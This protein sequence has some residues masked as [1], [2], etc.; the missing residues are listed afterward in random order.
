M[1][2]ILSS[3]QHPFKFK[4]LCT[5]ISF[6]LLSSTGGVAVAQQDGP[7]V[8]EVIVTGSFIRR[9]E[10]FIAASPI[11]QLSAEDI[12]DQG[13]LNMSQIV[14]NMTFN[15]GTG[16]TTGIQA[17][18]GSANSGGFNLRGLGR[19]AT[20]QLVDG[21]RITNSNIQTLIPNIAIQRMDIVTDGAAALYGTDA[22]AGVINFLPYKS[23]DGLKLEHFNEEDSEGDFRDQTTS[24]LWGTQL[25]DD[26]DFVIAGA[27]RHNG[28]LKWTDRPKLALAG[29][30]D[31]SGSNPTSW[32]VPDRDDDGALLGTTTRTPEPICGTDPVTDPMVQ[33]NNKYGTLALGRCWMPF[34]DTRDYLNQKT[35]ANLYSNLNWDVN[36]DLT[37]GAQLLWSRAMI[38]ARNNQGNPGTRNEDLSDIRGELP[39]NPYRAQS[40]DGRDLFAVPR[41]YA[42]GDII[43]DQH[44]AAQPLRDADGVVVLATNQFADLGT[45]PN[46]GVPFN[47]DMAFASNWL[48]FGKSNTFPAAFRSD[49]L[50][51]SDYDSRSARLAFTAD[52]T[53]P[54]LDGWEGSSSYNYAW[55][56]RVNAYHQSFSFSAVEQGLNCDPITDAISCWNP[57]GTEEDSPYRNSQAIADAVYNRDRQDDVDRLWTFDLILNGTI[58]PGGF[59][60]PGGPIGAAFGYQR[61]DEED[62]NVPPQNE[63]AND[64]LNSTQMFQAKH[65]RDS[66]SFFAEFAFPVLSNFEINASVR[67]E[68]FSTGQD[69]VVSKFGFTY[70]PLDWL[71]LRGTWGEAFIVPTLNQLNALDSCG[72]SNVDDLFTTFSGFITSCST[73]NPNLQ[74]ETADSWSLGFDLTPIDGL[75]IHFSWSETDF[76]DRI[77][78]TTT[79]DIL[80]ADFA[81]FQLHTGFAATDA[82]PLPS[83]QQLQDWISN[84]LSDPRIERDPQDIQTTTRIN[85]SNTNASTM[86]I[87]AADLS[88]NYRFTLDDIGLNDV[89]NWLGLGDAGNW[90]EFRVGLEATYFDSYE[91]QESILTPVREAKGNQNNSFG[92]VPN[93]PEWR[94]NLKLGWSRGNHSVSATVRYIDSMVFDANQF[95]FQQYLRAEHNYRSNTEIDAWTEMAMYYTYRDLDL[96]YLPGSAT[97]SLGARNIFDREAQKTGMIAGAITQLQSVLGRVIYVRVNYDF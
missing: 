75:D 77:V 29:L 84:P 54:Y 28:T 69:D 17:S 8:E 67:D 95:S 51:W 36:D 68:D 20:L 34:A 88:I 30:T 27:Y 2:D 70:Q 83:L 78:N 18:G 79:Q 74:V 94:A 33:G 46:G 73:G 45:D 59:E 90:G 52:F 35:Q 39:G 25:G 5:A 23:Y 15:A 49:N 65:S 9:S 97:L 71:S 16:V 91:W 48:P 61:R 47:E 12:T 93:I 10:G 62:E 80:R 82:Q 22:V 6:A 26:V 60:L 92:A 55:T 31:N 7:A 19:R 3:K 21:L 4:P 44:G 13:T 81:K 85:R 63:Q 96:P 32:N 57:F 58:S 66:D 37:L 40:G 50:N 38:H 24:F 64:R 89:G 14:Q 43:T 76:E 41:R 72:L 87:R 11:M 56:N 53:V 42:N 1:S 86:D